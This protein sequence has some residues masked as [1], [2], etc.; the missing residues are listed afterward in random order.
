MRRNNDSLWKGIT[1]E[2]FDDLLRFFFPKADTIIDFSRG[3]DF[4]DKEL[5]VMYP[6]PDKASDTRFVDKLV[7][8]YRL[9]GREEYLL[10]HVE[11]QGETKN[12]D[13]PLFA[14]RMFRYFTRIFNKDQKPV[15]AIAIFTAGDGAKMPDQYEYDFLGTTLVYRYNTY[16]IIDPTDEELITSN[17]P[18]AQV[19]LAARV[20]LLAGKL[21]DWE[22]K[23]RKLLVARHLLGKKMYAKGKIDVILSFL[24]NYV[25][26]E[27]PEINRK[28]DEDIDQLT[29][30]QNTMGIIEILAEQRAEKALEQGLEQGREEG[31]EEGREQARRAHEKSIKAFL[32]TT[33]F[34][35]E[36]IA[37]LLDVPVSFVEK[38]K[39]SLQYK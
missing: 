9:D 6:E 20:A 33:D 8:V 12:K 18:F 17:N 21:T 11:I 32:D 4:L 5:A 19:V 24:R 34:S 29:G 23:D 31:R 3:F 30:K 1:E 22:L 13:R 39:D 14:E 37:S 26:F 38:V 36:K 10:V 16:R 35:A 25:V 7:K 2:V 15:T 27:D 28:F